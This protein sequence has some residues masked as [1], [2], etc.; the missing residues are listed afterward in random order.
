MT[1]V[2]F[3]L[4]KTETSKT[5]DGNLEISPPPLSSLYEIAIRQY[6]CRLPCASELYC[7]QEAPLAFSGSSLISAGHASSMLRAP[8]FSFL[9]LEGQL[10]FEKCL[11]A[12]PFF[13]V[14]ERVGAGD[15]DRCPSQK[16]QWNI[17]GEGLR[18]GAGEEGTAA[19]YKCA[20][21]DSKDLDVEK[22]CS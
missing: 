16:E 21:P 7:Q 10:E 12:L 2:F 17:A 8:V 20:G 9:R 18:L 11:R 6:I 13:Q 22:I 3:L 1:T 15:S 4:A 14:L 19:G 5:L